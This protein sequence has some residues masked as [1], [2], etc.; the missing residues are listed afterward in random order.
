[1]GDFLQAGTVTT[2]HRL[3]GSDPSV[4]AQELVKIG[5]ERPMALLVPALAAEMDG[6]AFPKILLELSGAAFLSEFVV[7]LGRAGKN[8]F[9]RA[10]SLLEPLPM[11][12]T[13][14]WPEGPHLSTVLKEAE[15]F[16][17]LGGPGKGRDV[18]I[19]LGYLLAGD[20]LHS[21][22]LHDA[23]ILTYTVE[24]PSRLLLP[25][26]DPR[27]DFSFCKGYYARVTDRL[28]GR[29]TRLLVA[30]LVIV[31][32]RMF[33]SPLLDL[34]ESLRY[35]LAGEFA[36]TSEL[37]RQLPIPRNW[38]LEIGILASVLRET[39]TKGICQS[40]ICE[41]YRHKHQELSSSDAHKGLNRMAVEVA[42]TLLSE[43]SFPDLNKGNLSDEFAQE[44]LGMIPRYRADAL[45]NGLIYDVQKEKEAIETFAGSI[46]KSLDN[47]E[48]GVAA[49]PLPSWSSTENLMPGFT[50]AIVEAV[51]KD[52]AS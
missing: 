31:L 32:K 50:D 51:V 29:V 7:V 48:R 18:W 17:D 2:I 15:G 34:L 36:M 52:S 4:L 25:V 14:I 1:L 41:N 42:Q 20:K 21:I 9:D 39:G 3:P 40:D 43:I 5:G 49:G 6:E 44:A 16:P 13:V 45:A 22:G 27:L 33:S 37:A 11:K 38:G 30:P 28:N 12:N 24:M 46:R 10:R 47:L 19:A 23:D 26:S 8:E 35:P